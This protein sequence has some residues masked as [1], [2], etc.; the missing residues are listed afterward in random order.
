[1]PVDPLVPGAKGSMAHSLWSTS[2]EA[3][4][5]ASFEADSEEHTHQM[6]GFSC[7]IF[8]RTTRTLAVAWVPVPSWC[9]IAD[10]LGNAVTFLRST[11][12]APT[13]TLFCFQGTPPLF[14]PKCEKVEMLDVH[15][16]KSEAP[17]YRAL[18][19]IACGWLKPSFAIA[20]W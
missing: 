20:I 11:L 7:A 16:L 5:P 4:A 8:R 2:W 13:Y 14:S 17:N 9:K 10:I 1:M 19:P 3:G 18:M 12:R 15:G 6:G